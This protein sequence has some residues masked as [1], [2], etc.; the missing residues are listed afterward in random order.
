[1]V[2]RRLRSPAGDFN[3]QLITRRRLH[4]N[5]CGGAA[6]VDGVALKG[7]TSELAARLVKKGRQLGTRR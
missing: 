7:P 2:T 5:E 1:M 3:C 4:G 6:C